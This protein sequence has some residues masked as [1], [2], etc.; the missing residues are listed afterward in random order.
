MDDFDEM[1]LPAVIAEVHKVIG[2]GP[3]YLTLD[4][5]GIDATYL[6]GT[7]LPEPFGLTSREV[8]NLI[9]GFRGIDMVGADIVELCPLVDV[10]GTSA[11]L[12]SALGFEILTLL[13]EAR[14]KRTGTI[15]KTHWPKY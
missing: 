13:S 1:G 14:V 9:R 3:C 5:D 7:Q 2:D 8:R 15:N 6:P 11:N 12:M 10:R 4:S